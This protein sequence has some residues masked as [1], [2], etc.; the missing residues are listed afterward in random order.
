MQHGTTRTESAKLL[1]QPGVQLIDKQHTTKANTEK[2]CDWN[3]DVP[4]QSVTPIVT[5]SG[6]NC[7]NRAAGD[8]HDDCETT[9]K[10]VD[11]KVRNT[12]HKPGRII[13]HKTAANI[14]ADIDQ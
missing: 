13:N 4:H 6:L 12:C 7:E 14:A 8:D 5:A 3:P 1:R 9:P 11:S 2:C 10:T